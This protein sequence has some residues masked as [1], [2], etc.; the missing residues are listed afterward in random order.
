MGRENEKNKK[1]KNVLINNKSLKY[2]EN[3]HRPKTAR[4]MLFCCHRVRCSCIK[5]TGGLS[6]PA[7]YTHT[8]RHTHRHTLTQT[9]PHTD[10]HTHTHTRPTHIHTRHR[11]DTR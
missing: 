9:H 4:L 5:Q 3:L 1:K 7:P 2:L 8:H 10:T 11:H 6:G